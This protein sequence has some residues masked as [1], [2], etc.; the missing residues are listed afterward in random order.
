MKKAVVYFI[1]NLLF[2]LLACFFGI[3]MFNDN[4][5]LEGCD[6]DIWK[7]GKDFGSFFNWVWGKQPCRFTPGFT[8]GFYFYPF[9]LYAGI[10]TY[11]AQ[12]YHQAL[13]LKFIALEL[14]IYFS[15]YYG[16][17]IYNMTSNGMELNFVLLFNAFGGCL[18]FAVPMVVFALMIVGAHTKTKAAIIGPEL[19]F[20]GGLYIA[21]D[22]V[23]RLSGIYFPAAS[24]LHS[25]LLFL[26]LLTLA[27]SL[28]WSTPAFISTAVKHFPRVSFFCRYTGPVAYGQLLL[29]PLFNLS[30]VIANAYACLCILVSIV[31]FYKTFEKIPR[32]RKKSAENS[33]DQS[34]IYSGE[35]LIAGGFFSV[36]SYIFTWIENQWLYNFAL[37]VFLA[38]LIMLFFNRIPEYIKKM[39]KQC[40]KMTIYLQYLGVP[41]YMILFI[42]LGDIFFSSLDPEL[43]QITRKSEFTVLSL[44]FNL[45]IYGSALGMATYKAFFAAKNK[46]P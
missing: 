3:G 33:I 32:E 25:L 35:T 9:I 13:K 40:P 43:L 34:R 37:T 5:H 24:V 11:A 19:L 17:L 18:R 29:L 46:Q 20:A 23:V 16:V 8:F 44:V 7:L 6:P 10:K 15:L 42:T 39:Q 28:L 45:V 36:I 4:S 21:L 38:S 27:V 1:L 14:L 41:E 12:N 30:V 26:F 31:A 22:T 2:I